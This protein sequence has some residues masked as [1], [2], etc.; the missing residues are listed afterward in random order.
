VL[1]TIQ[2]FER[3]DDVHAFRKRIEWHPEDLLVIL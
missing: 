1:Q 3:R 2:V